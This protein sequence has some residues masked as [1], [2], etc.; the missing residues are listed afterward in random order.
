MSANVKAADAYA[1]DR[2]EFE[3]LEQS[4]KKTKQQIKAA[5]SES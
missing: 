4:I 3:K 2:L 1:V 5:Q